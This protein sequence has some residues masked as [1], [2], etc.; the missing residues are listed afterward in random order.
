MSA[1]EHTTPSAPGAGGSEPAP[2]VARVEEPGGHEGVPIVKVLALIPVWSTTMER[3]VE[4]ARKCEKVV[5]KLPRGIKIYT[6]DEFGKTYYTPSR[7]FAH[8]PYIFICKRENYY[9]VLTWKHDFEVHGENYAVLE[10]FKLIRRDKGL[11]YAKDLLEFTVLKKF[12]AMPSDFIVKGKTAAITKNAV[13]MI[14]Q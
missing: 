2:A 6:L 14:P 10:M 12:T 4:I 13:V 11:Y 3:I 7:F 5:D 9:Y 1:P 8:Q